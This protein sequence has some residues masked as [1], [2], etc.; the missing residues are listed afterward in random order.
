M[1]YFSNGNPIN[2]ALFITVTNFSL[3][4]HSVAFVNYRLI[5]Y[6]GALICL[7]DQLKTFVFH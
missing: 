3:L 5:L 7:I 2:L 6:L 4:N 1:H